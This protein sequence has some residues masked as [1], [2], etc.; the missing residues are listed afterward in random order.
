MQGKYTEAYFLGMISQWR[1]VIRGSSTGGGRARSKM[2]T[3]REK[4]RKR[5]A[6]FEDMNQVKRRE[7][8]IHQQTML[9]DGQTQWEHGTGIL[10]AGFVPVRE[11]HVVRLG[12]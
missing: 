4:S 3:A 7:H 6:L 12:R 10:S 9:T 1:V 8:R 2:K 11:G 5:A